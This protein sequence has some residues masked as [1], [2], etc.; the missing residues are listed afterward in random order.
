MKI[1]LISVLVVFTTFFG[2][3]MLFTENFIVSLMVASLAGIPIGYLTSVL[4]T[5]F[6]D[7]QDFSNK[8][9]EVAFK[10][11]LRWQQT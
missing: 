7:K 9:R 6:Y 11:N 3:G 8:E 5:V 1:R 10:K 4:M 2:M